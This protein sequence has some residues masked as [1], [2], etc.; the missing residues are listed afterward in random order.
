MTDNG[1]RLDYGNMNSQTIRKR[2]RQEFERL[3]SIGDE[4]NAYI[5]Q[6]GVS[7][8]AT[9]KHFMKTHDYCENY[10]GGLARTARAFPSSERNP[11]VGF[12]KHQ[13]LA[14]VSRK[15]LPIQCSD[16]QYRLALREA[17]TVIRDTELRINGLNSKQVVHTLLTE[18]IRRIC[19]I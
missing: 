6:Q 16:I 19:L 10:L 14:E 18:C 15:N 3:F 4:I 7:Q 5:N 11:S 12:T 2:E 9:C 8:S 13:S 17:L 1:C